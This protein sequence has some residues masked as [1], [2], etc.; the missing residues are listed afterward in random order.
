MPPR[1]SDTI[2][3]SAIPPFLRWAGSKRRLIP[4][5]LPYWKVGFTRYLEPFAGSSA[6]FFAAKPDQAVLS[7]INGDLIE[8]LTSVGNQPEQ[9]HSRLMQ[10]EPSKTEFYRIRSQDPKSLDPLDRVARF[11]YLNRFCFNGLYRTNAAGYFNV[12]Y[13]PTGTGGVPSLQLFLRC[14]GAL[15]KATLHHGDFNDVVRAEVRE[16]DFVY[17]DPPY[18]VANRRIFRQ[19]GPQTF[20]LEDVAKLRDLL[21]Y[22]D[23][24]GAS[25]LLSY[26]ECTEARSLGSIWHHKRV[27]TQRNIAGFQR[28]RRRAAEILIT[29]IEL[30]REVKCRK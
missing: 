7:D 12:P 4:R 16:G 17:L 24:V 18:A 28:H 21:T 1:R 19:Y 8:V 26:A 22:I 5:L 13:A 3:N 9:V 27:Y 10:L 30:P 11:V 25:F 6:L 29:N 23:S 20:G 15:R 14:A 2:A